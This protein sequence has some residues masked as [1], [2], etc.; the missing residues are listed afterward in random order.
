MKLTGS[1]HS[2]SLLSSMSKEWY[3]TKSLMSAL[4]DSYISDELQH[5][6]DTLH[7][8]L[9][10]TTNQH[11]PVCRLRTTLLEQ[12]DAGFGVLETHRHRFT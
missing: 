7:H 6:L 1:I 2:F 12:L 5:R 8:S 4:Q 11:H 9:R 10:F 3:I